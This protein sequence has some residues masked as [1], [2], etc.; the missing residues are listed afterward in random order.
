MQLSIISLL[1]CSG[2]A[3]RRLR[4]EEPGELL[5]R[6]QE[7]DFDS[8]SESDDLDFSQ[9]H[10]FH[11][12][13]HDKAIAKNSIIHSGKF[14]DW[15][16]IAKQKAH[17]VQSLQN[18]SILM[19]GDSI[20][21]QFSGS[22]A[23]IPCYQPCHNSNLQGAQSVWKEF[24]V[25][26][27]GNSH[28]SGISGD[29][30]GN[31]LW[32]LQ[33]GE[34]PKSAQPRVMVLAIGT[35]DMPWAHNG[36]GDVEEIFAGYTKVVEELQKASP[37]SDIVLSGILPRASPMRDKKTGADLVERYKQMIPALNQKIAGLANNV[38]IHFVDCGHL[39]LDKQGE[40][41]RNLLSD[42]VH[43]SPAGSKV[44]AECLQPT[45]DHILFK[46]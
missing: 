43:P 8:A 33:H 41:D 34:G 30:V 17:E 12:G 9:E 24:F 39:M 19:Y 2:N 46:N 38:K 31:L 36:E 22:L 26:R 40:I 45:L 11:Q 27:Y 28:P 23:G 3:L 13:H 7:S 20:V 18:L 16:K 5:R 44:L 35:N 32:R 21:E 4:I 10:P 29:S 37:T 14:L 25:E 6:E 15:H 1:V 42:F